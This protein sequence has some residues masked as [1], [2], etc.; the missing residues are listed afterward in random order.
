MASLWPNGDLGLA[1][2]TTYGAPANNK[3]LN[4]YF[5]YVQCV[6]FC[7]A[8]KTFDAQKFESHTAEQKL[9]K[10]SDSSWDQNLAEYSPS[11]LSV[12]VKISCSKVDLI[13]EI[14]CM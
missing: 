8:P 9:S 14:V 4:I 6:T 7:G 10:G 2:L 1:G 11:K 5:S 3:F 13:C 12:K